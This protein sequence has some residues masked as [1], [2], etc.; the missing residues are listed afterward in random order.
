MPEQVGGIFVNPYCAGALEFLLTVPAGQQSY[1]KGSR[2]T[3]GKHVPDRI[4]DHDRMLD[5]G[6]KPVSGRQKKVGIR[7]AILYLITSYYRDHAWIDAECVQ[8]QLGGL[9]PTA[10]GDRPWTSVF[11]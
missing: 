11:R 6:A 8:I 3:C 5:I 4:P 1:A 7:L 9:H 2:P 10:G